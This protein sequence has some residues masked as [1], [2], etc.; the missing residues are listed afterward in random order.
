MYADPTKIDRKKYFQI[1]LLY[2]RQQRKGF[3]AEFIEFAKNMSKKLDCEGRLFL[4]ADKEVYGS[5]TPPQ[6]FYRKQGFTTNDKEYLKKID[7]F[8]KEGKEMENKDSKPIYMYY[9]PNKR[10]LVQKIK[11]FFN[12]TFFT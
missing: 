12:I 5:K 8:I 11:D 7:K 1:L 3:G 9:D 4:L 10:S 6:I 2:V